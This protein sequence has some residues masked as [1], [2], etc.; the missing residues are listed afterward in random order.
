MLK[1][2]LVCMLVLTLLTILLPINGNAS[3]YIP[4]NRVVVLVYDDSGSMWFKDEQKTQ[5]IDNWKF[6]NYSLQS[7]IALLDEGDKIIIVPLSESSKVYEVTINSNNRQ[8]EIHKTKAIQGQEGTPF[9]RVTKA[10]EILKEEMDQNTNSEFWMIVLTDGIFNE[11]AKMN[12]EED[13]ERTTATLQ[14]FKEFVTA[15]G[16]I[17][18]NALLTFESYLNDKEKEKMNLF[19][20]VWNKTLGGELI[21][22]ESGEDILYKVHEVAALVT[23]R[24]PENKKG[25]NL[26]PDDVQEN[27]LTLTS[28][29]PLRRITILNQSQVNYEPL[30]IESVSFTGNKE[31]SLIDGPYFIKTMEDELQISTSLSGSVT[32]VK[33]KEALGAIPAGQYTLT[34]KEK[35]S[36]DQLEN[37]TI[38]AEPSI[39]FT[40]AYRKLN[41]DGTSSNNSDEFYIGNKMEVQV[42]LY[43][44]GSKT[45]IL[46]LTKFANLKELLDVSV[47]LGNKTMKLDWNE[48]EQKFIGQ[49]IL[50]EDNELAPT[51][52]VH[53]KGFYYKKRE[54]QLP[55]KNIRKLELKMVTG[56]WEGKLNELK[57]V[58]PIAFIPLVNGKMMTE[59]ELTQ[60]F[61]E[62]KVKLS[63]GKHNLNVQIKQNHNVILLDPQPYKI[64]KLTSTGNIQMTL[65][66]EG[67]YPGEVASSQFF[68]VI[69]DIPFMEKWGSWIWTV[70][71]IFILL[72]YGIGII[73]KPR[74]K[75]NSD[76]IDY[77][78]AFM[79]TPHEKH[80]TTER[81]TSNFFGKWFIPYLPEKCTI[82][83]LTIKAT[84]NGIAL[85]KESQRSDMIVANFE[86]GEKAGEEDIELLVNDEIIM[87]EAQLTHTFQYKKN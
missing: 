19:K 52:T 13:F 40:V 64:E 32:H 1:N 4:K 56:K 9:K 66:I 73:K 37:L 11:F 76:Y 75:G 5:P 31:M 10:F 28:P 35:I 43:K 49:F 68:I 86:L 61:K 77:S 36:Q 74:F 81:L 25:I 83:S 27:K 14:S 39:D 17:F 18:K 41:E 69:E 24:D 78:Y 20:K 85:S 33:Y 48:Q 84:K 58:Q 51:T 38:F 53:I 22:G 12:S 7:L 62:Q 65:T 67:K 80:F 29:F 54:K 79:V 3:N 21:E 82:N 6:A 26:E 57:D 55:R 70:L 15:K 23:N 30:M 59:D 16:V 72:I 44:S 60:L 63:Y 87:K 8:Q 42:T 50:S 2:G 46:N 45:E 47:N 71:I 34:F